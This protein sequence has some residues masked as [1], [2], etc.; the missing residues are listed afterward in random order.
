M[1]LQ[2]GVLNLANQDY[3]LDPLTY[4]I[5]PCRTRSFYTSFKFNF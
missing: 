5:D 3:R 2:V 4:Y 1:E